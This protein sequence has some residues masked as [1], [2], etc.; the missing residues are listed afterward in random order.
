MS[1]RGGGCGV[2]G[3]NEERNKHVDE[4]LVWLEEEGEVDSGIA[5]KG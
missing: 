5:V 1:C 2:S 3:G 4:A